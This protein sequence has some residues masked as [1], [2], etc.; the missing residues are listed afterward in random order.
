MDGFCETWVQS[1]ALLK[2]FGGCQ[3][4]MLSDMQAASVSVVVGESFVGGLGDLKG[5]RSGGR[6]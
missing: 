1:R 5:K 2:M 4:F 6:D 3:G